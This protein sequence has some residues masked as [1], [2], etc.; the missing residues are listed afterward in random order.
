M[1]AFDPVKVLENVINRL[2]QH[3]PSGFFDDP[4]TDKEAPNYSQ[5][6]VDEFFWFK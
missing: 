2:R 6:L 5:V 4:V 3:D 1:A